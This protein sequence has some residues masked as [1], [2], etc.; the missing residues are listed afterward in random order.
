MKSRP[1]P[2]DYALALVGTG[3]TEWIVWVNA[4]FGNRIA[5]PRWATA[6]LPLL[7]DLPLIA[8]RRAPLASCVLVFAGIDVHAV[9]TGNSAEGLE[10]LFPL[11]V[12]V[13]SVAEYG[14]RRAALAGL[15][16]FAGAYTVFS[17]DDRNVQ[18]GAPG[19]TWSA[20]FFGVAGIALWFA[21]VWM[22]SRR[23]SADLAARAAELER[24]ARAAV[25]DERARM[26]R[27]LHDIVS[28]NLS[29]VV[30]QAA[31]AR[32]GGATASTLE[33]IEHSGREALTE[34]R[35]LLGVLRE[36]GGSG[37]T[38][39]PQPGLADL[40]RLADAVRAAGVEVD[41]D[42][43][44]THL[45]SALELA[46]YRIVQESLTNVMKHA[47]PARAAVRVVHEN[48]L[49]TVEIHDNGGRRPTDRNGGHGLAGMAERVALFGGEL[50]AGPRPEGGFAVHAALPVGDA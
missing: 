37:E 12:A 11:A 38:L 46:V 13:Y 49:V 4:D 31:G 9:A 8:R 22:N 41:L 16:A 2:V 26:A 1:T 18:S 34:M 50:R 45:P 7:I 30:L 5:G 21:G 40:E 24:D 29:V 20:A 48:G 14:T 33:K 6:L 25:A 28:H 39:S 19:Q 47:G 27:E 10:I 35:R 43:P 3:L 36:D 32:A 44:A 42:V 15:A 17:L 23:H